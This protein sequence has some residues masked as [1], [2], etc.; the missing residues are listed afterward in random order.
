MTLD[1]LGIDNRRPPAPTDRV[2]LVD[3]V[4]GELDTPAPASPCAT[5]TNGS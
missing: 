1:R 5:T 3:T 2:A 4:P